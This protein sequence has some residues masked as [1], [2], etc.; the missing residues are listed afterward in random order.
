MLFNNVFANVDEM[1]TEIIIS[2]C[3]EKSNTGVHTFSE[4]ILSAGYAVHKAYIAVAEHSKNFWFESPSWSSRFIAGLR[5][6]SST[7]H[8]GKLLVDTIG[9]LVKYS[10][11][12]AT[13]GSV[14]FS[15]TWF[16]VAGL[17]AASLEKFSKGNNGANLALLYMAE[18]KG[19]EMIGETAFSLY[20]FDAFVPSSLNV[21]MHVGRIILKSANVV[22]DKTDLKS[23]LYTLGKSMY[24]GISSWF[25]SSN[26][27]AKK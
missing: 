26:N 15:T 7:V 27:T 11:G 16:L 18:K 24:N 20:G 23:T 8:G 6:A 10:L 14:A 3:T 19:K 21:P 4:T 9:T 22:L 17:I 25:W 1:R 13:L 2:D 12:T 5:G